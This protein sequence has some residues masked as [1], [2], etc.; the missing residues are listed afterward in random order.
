MSPPQE[1]PAAL[2]PGKPPMSTLPSLLLSKHLLFMAREGVEPWLS[3]SL[4]AQ[5]LCSAS[6]APQ[7]CLLSCKEETKGS[8]P[9]REPCIKP[10]HLPHHSHALHTGWAFGSPPT[11]TLKSFLTVLLMPHMRPSGK[12]KPL[13]I[14][15]K[16]DSSFPCL[17]QP[18]W[19]LPACAPLRSLLLACAA[20]LGDSGSC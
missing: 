3:P 7:S 5:S 19:Q 14:S 4:P 17:Q 10:R 16:C 8:C 1:L 13:K 15:A 11:M 18:G 2:L 12:Q 9:D 20:V 6:A